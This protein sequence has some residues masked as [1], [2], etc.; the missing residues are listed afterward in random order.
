MTKLVRLHPAARE[1]F[2]EA[3]SWYAERDPAVADRFV[4]AL[5]TILG[6]LSDHPEIGPVWELHAAI[7]RIPFAGFP[8]VAFYRV[9]EE[10][11]VVSIA[12]SSRRPG[13]WL[14]RLS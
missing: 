10:V 9:R 7:R 1:E 4:D 5:Q 14:E 8:F 12:H 11:Q 2:L 3:N 13:Y 6:R